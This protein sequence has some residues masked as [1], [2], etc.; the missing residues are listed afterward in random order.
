MRKKREQPKVLVVENEK[1]ILSS[2]VDALNEAG[3]IAIG[4][5]SGEEGLKIVKKDKQISVIISDFSMDGMT[6][7]EFCSKVKSSPK[8][9]HICFIGE[10]GD[11]DN[12]ERFFD[13]SADGFVFYSHRTFYDDIV[14]KVRELVC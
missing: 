5:E 9:K 3:F 13:A 7:A 12:K 2:I 4:V 1:P 8:L 14:S 11:M 10:S 6:G